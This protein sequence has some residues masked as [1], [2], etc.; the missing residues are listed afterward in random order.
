MAVDPRKEHDDD[1]DDDGDDD[2]DDDDDGEGDDD[3]D[4]GDADEDDDDHDYADDDDD[5]DDDFETLRATRTANHTTPQGGGGTESR[6]TLH[7][8]GRGGEG[9]AEPG[10]YMPSMRGCLRFTVYI[11]AWLKEMMRVTLRVFLHYPKP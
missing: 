5:D 4:D 9:P 11:G 7:Q 10:S 2:D 6:T 1:D 3:D 8:K